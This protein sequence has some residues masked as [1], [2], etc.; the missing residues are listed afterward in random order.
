VSA[1]AQAIGSGALGGRLWFYAN[2]HC[3]LRCSYCLTESGPDVARRELDGEAILARAGEAEEL[4]FTAF[5]VTGGEPFIRQD[6]P[7]LVAALGRRRPTVV[8]SNGTLFNSRRLRALE[9]LADL[10]V[11]VQISLD[12]PDPDDNDA[13]RGPENFRKVLDA[14]PR[15]VERGIGVRIATTLEDPDAVDPEERE[16]LCELHRSMGV[17][18]EDHVVRPIINRGRAR[19]QRDGRPGGLRAARSPE[20]TLTAD[21][22]FYSP[23]GPTVRGGRPRHRP[24]RSRATA[25]LQRPVEALLRIADSS[26]TATTRAS[27]SGERD[28]AARSG[29]C[30]GDD[31]TSARS[32][33]SSSG[34]EQAPAAGAALLRRRPAEPDHR[35]PGAGPRAARGDAALHR[36][37]ARIRV[38]RRAAKELAVL[39]TSAL[40]ECRY[41]VRPTRSSPWTAG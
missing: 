7:A 36:G 1:V 35:V 27:A 21:G 22:A 28:P 2:Y 34:R 38:A 17:P 8:L 40:L 29:G 15:L 13:M 39:R 11:H 3:N 23:F 9:P 30:E 25:P 19:L 16:R 18:D 41:C 14:I 4:G 31:V 26:R 24:A 32:W 10:P 37:G 33:S 12:R 5:G 20:L 6:M